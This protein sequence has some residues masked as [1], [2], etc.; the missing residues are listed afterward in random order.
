METQPPTLNLPLFAKIKEKILAEPDR[1]NMGLWFGVI[2]ARGELDF[3]TAGAGTV[4]EAFQECGTVACI[5]G[6]AVVLGDPS[7]SLHCAVALRARAALGLTYDEGTALFTTAR[8]PQELQDAYFKAEYNG[9]L[10][11]MARA[12][13]DAIDALVSDRQS[14]LTRSLALDN[15]NGNI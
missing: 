13:C 8:W 15:Y 14:F 5:A 1:F 11:A 10:L 12:A 9:D 6:W 3:L 4:G 2:D 7:R